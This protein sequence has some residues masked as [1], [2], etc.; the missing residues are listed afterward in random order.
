MKERKQTTELKAIVKEFNELK[1]KIFQGG[2]FVEMDNTPEQ[3]RYNELL[4]TLYPQFKI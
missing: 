4:G 2:S 3:K 1:D